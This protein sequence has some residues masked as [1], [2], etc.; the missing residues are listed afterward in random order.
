MAVKSEATVAVQIQAW[1]QHF[2]VVLLLFTSVV[3]LYMDRVNISVVAPVLMQELGWDPAVMGTVLSAFFVGYFLTQV[4]GGWLSDRWGSKGILGGAVAWW[5]LITILTPFA[6]N[7]PAMLTVRVSMGLGEGLSPPCLYSTVARWV[8]AG[9]RSRTIAFIA[10][11]M[12]V[13]LIIAYPAA[14]WIMARLGWPWVFYIFGLLGLVWCGVWHLLA[15]NKPEDHPR[16]SP[17]ELHYILQGHSS[18]TQAQII[19]WQ[20]FFRERAFWAL[21]CAHFCTN[22][23]WYIFLTWLPAYLV[24][25]RGFSLAEMGVYATFPYMAMMIMGNAAAWIA[26]GMIQRGTRVTVVRKLF[27]TLAF[28][29]A[30]LFL[31]VLTQSASAWL[32]VLCITLG[33]G[34]LSCFASG[35][36]TNHLDIGPKYAGVLVGITNTAATI[37]G[38]LAP[39]ITG[40]II[41]WTG[42]WNM[43][44]YLAAAI[45]IVGMVIWNLFAT[46]EKL[47]E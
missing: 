44:F 13:G 42:D 47:F 6:R 23:T 12:Y 32:T 45:M 3:I 25:A 22:W 36:G 2:N 21:L 14:V 4:P 8:P 35:M 30:A 40:F 11:G 27:Q 16:V 9:E 10:T 19:P 29:G 15:T 17:A 43:V 34:S 1:P 26:D 38:I 39:A 18:T 33:L 28:M 5:S 46:G 7:L 41:Q 24:Q 20:R 37:P 31:L